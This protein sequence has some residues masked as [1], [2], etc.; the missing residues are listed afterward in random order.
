MAKKV[1]V[2]IVD[3]LDGTEPAESVRFGLDGADY[4]IDLNEDN[5]KQLREALSPFVGS[6][7]RLSGARRRPS[8]SSGSGGNASVVRAWARENGHDVPA[9]GRIPRE[10][11]EAYDAAH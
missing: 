1:N 8:G 3:D 4:E 7:R 10:I 5:A 9:R 11:R 6:A 2:I